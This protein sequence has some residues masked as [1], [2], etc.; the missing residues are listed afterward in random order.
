MQRSLLPV[1]LLSAALGA[2][3]AV[4]I[5]GVLDVGGGNTTTTVVQ[6]APPVRS[7]NPSFAVSG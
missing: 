1:V 5:V 3:A 6:P 2:G 7:P 4:A